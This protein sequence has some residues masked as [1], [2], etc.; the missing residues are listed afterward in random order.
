MQEGSNQLLKAFYLFKKYIWAIVAVTVLFGIAGF[1]FTKQFITPIYKSTTQLV[2]K[3]DAPTETLD[4]ETLNDA[5]YKLLMVNTYKN[6]V[7]SYA[8]L[9][10]VQKNLKEKNELNIGIDQLTEM[11]TVTQEENS[12]MFNIAVT[13]DN[14]TIAG[15]VA[16]VTANTFSEK[17]GALLGDEN[18]VSI[19]SPARTETSPISPNVKLNVV[20]FSLIGALLASIILFIQ[21]LYSQILAEDDH[22]DE[23]LGLINLGNVVEVKK[24]GSANN[25]KLLQVYNYD[26]SREKNAS[27]N[28]I[29]RYHTL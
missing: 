20:M 4:K 1:V 18:T 28:R 16:G 12:Q 5:N 14:P 13:S 19:I 27:K 21:S 25:E 6:L 24:S 11:I 29:G 17:V 22:I 10:D 3:T 2:A 7:K 9:E 23:S 15:L 26:E 8:I